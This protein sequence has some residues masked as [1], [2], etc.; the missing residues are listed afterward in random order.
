MVKD[1]CTQSNFFRTTYRCLRYRRAK[2]SQ[3][4]GRPTARNSATFQGP[5]HIYFKFVG[6]VDAEALHQQ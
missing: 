2:S 3:I 4:S 5:L 1:F 6:F